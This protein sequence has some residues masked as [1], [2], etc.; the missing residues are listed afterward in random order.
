MS[1]FH[2]GKGLPEPIITT[3]LSKSSLSSTT[4]SL[5]PS[6][7]VL[8]SRPS[9]TNSYRGSMPQAPLSSSSS[10]NS[11]LEQIIHNFFTKT[12]QIILQSRISDDHLKGHP[13]TNTRRKVNKWVKKKKNIHGYYFFLT[14]TKKFNIATSEDDQL[15]DELKFWKLFIKTHQDEEPPPLVIDIY[16]ET[17]E[18]EL[19]QEGEDGR[20][21][22]KL[23]LGVQCILIESWTLK[24]TH[25]LPEVAVDLPNLYKKS[26]VFF[27]SLHSL[28]RLLPGHKLYQ[29]LNG[30]H[31]E[32]DLRYRLSTHAINRPDEIP[33]D[34]KLTSMD[35]VQSYE[36]KHVVTPLGT[37]KL[38]LNYRNHCQFDIREIEPDKSMMEVEENFFTPTMTKYRQE[39][40][41]TVKAPTTL[42]PSVSSSSSRRTMQPSFRPSRS[43]YPTSSTSTVIT[44]LERRISAPIVQPFKSPSLSSSP[45]KELMYPSRSQTTTRPTATTTT[46]GMATAESGS[47]GRKVEFSSSFEKFKSVSSSNSSS[48]PRPASFLAAADMVRRGSRTS[49]QSSINLE[50]EEEEDLEDFMKFIGDPQELKLFQHHSVYSEV[51]PQQQE[52]SRLSHFRNMQETHTILSDSMSFS[53]QAK[54][55]QSSMESSSY[56]K[57]LNLPVRPSPLHNTELISP[58]ATS[59]NVKEVLSADEIVSQSPLKNRQAPPPPPPP[60]APVRR[61]STSHEDDDSLVFK[62]SELS[63]A[64]EDETEHRSSMRRIHSSGNIPST[65]KMMQVQTTGHTSDDGTHHRHQLTNRLFYNDL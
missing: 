5:S 4:S 56:N 6:A 41:S 19:L 11:K 30:Q 44:S 34:R 52:Q 49:D 33:L 39:R 55:N 20:G 8:Y 54:D 10:K 43:Y 45:Q 16:I 15:K 31:G 3:S 9:R 65:T 12:V 27:R 35:T 14:R 22:H 7:S 18:P 58:P 60:T 29:R 51:A 46:V 26:I 57:G 53:M 59:S 47:F 42:Y 17:S 2:D 48:H 32:I 24:L 40:E 36:F 25:P 63:G 64:Y 61:I 37:L 1:H 23:N 21:W 13:H 28:V 62:M 38:S 50:S